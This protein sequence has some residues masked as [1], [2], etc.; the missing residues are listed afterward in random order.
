MEKE[1]HPVNNH[2]LNYLLVSL[3]LSNTFPWRAEVPACEAAA[4]RNWAKIFPASFSPGTFLLIPC[5]SFFNSIKAKSYF[6]PNAKHSLPFPLP[7]LR[8]NRFTG[9]NISI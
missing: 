3:S 4:G 1:V 8:R 7:N 9:I 2:L 6:H 5:I